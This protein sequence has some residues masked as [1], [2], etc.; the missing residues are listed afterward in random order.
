MDKL[1]ERNNIMIEMREDGYTLA[2]I[3]NTFGVTRERARQITGH[4]KP[5]IMR[6]HRIIKNSPHLTNGELVELTGYSYRT[7]STSRPTGIYHAVEMGCSIGK[8]TSV[9]L[10]ACERIRLLGF[11]CIMMKFAHPFDLLVNG[12]L[13]ID[14]KSAY[15]EWA[16]PSIRNSSKFY[17]FSVGSVEKR[18]KSD[19]QIFVIVPTNSWFIIPTNEIDIS[20]SFVTFA[21]PLKTS[22]SKS[23][24]RGYHNRF[25][26]IGAEL[27]RLSPSE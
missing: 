26:L 17:R 3:G 14:V 16:P 23:K 8:G 20:G 27:E 19:L 5:E 21:W 6:R 9:E 18:N 12:A 22:S 7:V 4:I 15:R 1:T 25:D 24:W 2:E 10:A 11:D 13:R